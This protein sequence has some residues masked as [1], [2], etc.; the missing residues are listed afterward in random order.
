MCRGA[1]ARISDFTAKAAFVLK[2][3]EKDNGGSFDR[4]SG[5]DRFPYGGG[6]LRRG[7]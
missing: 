5:V 7:A 4:R 3:E 1:G 6:A 2:K